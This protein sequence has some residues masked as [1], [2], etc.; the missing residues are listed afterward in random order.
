MSSN[1]NA[2]P[3]AN[4]AETQPVFQVQRMYLKDASLEMPHAPQIFLEQETP[5]VEVAVDVGAT[6]LAEHIY[7]SVVTVTVTSKVGE[8]V[9]FLVEVKQGGIFEIA[10]LPE[11]QIDPL[12]GIVCP[13]MIYPYL[14][15]NVADL[16]NRT[17]FPPIHLADINFEVFYQQRIAAVAEQQAQA[18]AAAGGFDSG[19]VLP[20]G[21]A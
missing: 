14:R 21:H 17:G 20:P 9:A 3:A 19:I 16:I 15:A 18:T 1:D 5:S 2:A 10:R 6:R 4:A 13:N 12:L 8:K 11:E 7:E